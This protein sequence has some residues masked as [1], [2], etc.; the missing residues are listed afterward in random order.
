MRFLHCTCGH[1]GQTVPI[2]AVAQ[3]GVSGASYGITSA[4]PNPAGGRLAIEA[5]LP[6]G[7][8]AYVE[9]F[10]LRGRLLIRQEFPALQGRRRV[11][12]D[13]GRMAAGVYLIRA[14]ST[15]GAVLGSPKKV[16]IVR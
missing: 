16:V 5:T 12:V 9:V 15:D 8:P 11:D 2:T 4:A 7:R 6:P 10:D 3:S 13:L 14:R 1:F